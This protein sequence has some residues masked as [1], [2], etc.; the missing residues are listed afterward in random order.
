[1][2]D[3]GRQSWCAARRFR[4]LAAVVVVGWL[5]SAG[6]VVAQAPTPAPGGSAATDQAEHESG[7]NPSYTE[8]GGA[9]DTEP[10]RTRSGLLAVMLVTLLI[11]FG[12][13]AFVVR[14]DRR[15]RRL[16]E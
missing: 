11:W 6:F 9:A 13:F 15:V 10:E 5:V 16:E 3:D 7:I 14:L 8:V 1:M 4:F 12:L 2:I